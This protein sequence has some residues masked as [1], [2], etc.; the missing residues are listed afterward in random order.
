MNNT[1]FYKIIDGEIDALVEK[2]QNDE[3][4][5]KQD[6]NSRKSYGFLIWFLEFYGG[7]VDYVSSITEGRDDN[8]CDIIFDKYDAKDNNKRIFY[9]VQSKWNTIGKVESKPD[10]GDILQ[11]L[12]EFETILRGDIKEAVNEKLK[13]R[14]QELKEHIQSNGEV[15]FIFLSL[16]QPS[17]STNENIESFIKSQG[18]QTSFEF[19]DIN[20]IKNDYIDREYKGIKPINPLVKYYNPKETKVTLEIERLK[21]QGNHIKVDRPFEAYIFLIRPKTIFE[22]FE[23]YGFALFFE[24]IRNPLIQSNFNEDIE[25][26]AKENP[27]FFWYYN[28]GITAITSILP[29]IRNQAKTIEV[30]GFQIINGAQT[31][32]SLYKVYKEASPSKREQMDNQGLV[33]LRLMQSGGRDFDLNVTRFTNSQN[34]VKD[35]DFYANDLIQERLQQE[36]YQTNVWY[37]RR[38]GEFRKVPEGV[39]SVSNEHFANLYLAYFL[40]QPH[41]IFSLYGKEKKKNLNFISSK[42]DKEGRYEEIFNEKTLYEDML[43]AFYL[44]DINIENGMVVD[45]Y[46]LNA[47]FLFE[48]SFFQIVFEQYITKKYNSYEIACSRKL[49]ALYL[50]KDYSIVLKVFAF[51]RSF[52]EKNSTKHLNKDGKVILTGSNYNELFRKMN[53]EEIT[54]E[55]IEN[56]QI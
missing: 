6:T 13:A 38:R 42:V 49:I 24:N 12:N 53:L 26:T 35:R 23:K 33:T 51:I 30:T 50:K 7:I 9:I 32:Y 5:Q 2:Y 36:S 22:L 16:C 44:F 10:R 1:E 4:L 31:V 27:A 15:K 17:E 40:Q 8:S 18:G 34:P 41:K 14:L 21:E 3:F 20:R 43:C 56:I 45:E 19:I 11:A 47:G 55:D 39:S 28:N 48:L 37:E 54:V 52:I 25:Q 46:N 29:D